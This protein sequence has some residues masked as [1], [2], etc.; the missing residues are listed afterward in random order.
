MK[1]MDGK[2]KWD[3]LS[4]AIYAQNGNLLQKPGAFGI[5]YIL[6]LPKA[7]SPYMLLK[8]ALKNPCIDTSRGTEKARRHIYSARLRLRGACAQ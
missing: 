6:V 8:L 3:E 7:P 1:M 2:N 5:A 4:L